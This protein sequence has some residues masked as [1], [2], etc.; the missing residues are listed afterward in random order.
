M[1][2]DGMVGEKRVNMH[3]EAHNNVS[4]EGSKTF[5]FGHVCKATLSRC[6]LS[7]AVLNHC[8]PLILW[9][10]IHFVWPFAHVQTEK[11]TFELNFIWILKEPF[12]QVFFP[13]KDTVCRSCNLCQALHIYPRGGLLLFREKIKKLRVSVTRIAV[14]PKGIINSKLKFR[15]FTSLM[16]MEAWATFSN[17]LENIR[18][19][20]Q[21][22]VIGWCLYIF[23]TV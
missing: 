2:S 7:C 22:C 15:P 16:L 21:I 8:S 14:P 4:R 11:K 12:I 5:V 17:P 3:I 9:M 23:E 20:G 10:K 19:F 13:L 1:E 18:V 6:R